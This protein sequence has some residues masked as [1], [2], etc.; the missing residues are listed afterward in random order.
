[1]HAGLLAN[2]TLPNG[3][4]SFPKILRSVDRH[5]YWSR[6]PFRSGARYCRQSSET[7]RLKS[8]SSLPRRNVSSVPAYFEL[9]GRLHRLASFD[10]GVADEGRHIYRRY[11]HERSEEV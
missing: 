8:K 6:A 2:L 7:I 4:V 11:H 9:R 1:M 3:C 5:H 10:S